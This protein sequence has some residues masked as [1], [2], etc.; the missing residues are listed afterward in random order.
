MIT[1]CGVPDFDCCVSTVEK[2][3]PV[4]A[5]EYCLIYCIKV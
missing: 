3:A 1:G 2:L 5:L 4:V